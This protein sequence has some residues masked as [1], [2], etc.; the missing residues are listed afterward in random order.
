MVS[1]ANGLVGFYGAI[2]NTEGGKTSGYNANIDLQTRL[3]NGGSIRNQLYYSKCQF[4]L[5]SNFTF[6][7]EDPVNGDQIRQKEDRNIFGYN[8]SYQK[9][10]YWGNIKTEAKAGIQIRYGF[11]NNLELTRTKNRVIYH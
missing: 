2:D 9:E 7:K 5:Y 3:K 4:E 8:G 1:H 10:G 6:Y 11:I